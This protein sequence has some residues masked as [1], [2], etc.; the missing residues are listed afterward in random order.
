MGRMPL[1]DRRSGGSILVVCTVVIIA[2][3]SM[4]PVLAREPLRLAILSSEEVQ[5]SGISD[6]LTVQMQELENVELVER[7]LLRKV[8]D[9]LTLSMMLGAE[10]T[11]NRRNVGALL[12]A[13]MLV[14][15]SAE[16]ADGREPTLRI[17]IGDCSN[18]ARLRVGWVPFEKKNLDANCRQLKEITQQTLDH[19]ETGVK[20]IIGV[21]HFISRDLVHDYNHLQTGYARLLQSALS[22]LPGVAVIEVE[23]A[24]SIARENELAGDGKIDRV[25][26]LFVEGE[27]RTKKGGSQEQVTVHLKIRISDNAATAKEIERQDVALNQVAAFLTNDVAREILVLSK[28]SDIKLLDTEKQLEVLTRNADEF[29]RVGD[30][31]HSTELR[32][33]AVLLK[34]DCVEQRFKLIEE[35]WEA[36]KNPAGW[37]LSL[38]STSDNQWQLSFEHLEYMIFNR[39]VKMGQAVGLS[40]KAF[41][42]LPP[43]AK[44]YKRGFLLTAYPRILDLEPSKTEP[45]Q[46]QS[47]RQAWYSLL[48]RQVESARW[49]S[50][51]TQ[52]DLELY[53]QL[54]DTLPNDMGPAYTFIL[55]L[56]DHAKP[57]W[58]DD[59]RVRHSY[60]CSP[61]HDDYFSEEDFLDFTTALSRSIKPLSSLCGRYALLFHKYH[62][63]RARLEPVDSLLDQVKSLA[64]EVKDH[65]FSIYLS[66]PFCKKEECLYHEIRSLQAQIEQAISEQAED[67]HTTSEERTTVE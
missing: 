53:L 35:Y 18:G 54:H 65:K 45:G 32:E 36:R 1:W 25:V 8:A 52:E 44:P 43:L 56:Q 11:E 17:T 55:F 23:E 34:P 22:S 48:V 49:G 66:S 15:L 21:S 57:G 47:E 26:P 6:L 38:E 51:P 29:A 60:W 7:D 37:R 4:C 39:M 41:A 10:H 67:T 13:D 12:K 62:F 63:R 58:R 40:G 46:Q 31:R 24:R 5:N 50:C 16:K 61:G 20:Q 33:A 30:W 14:I 42:R 9:E 2:L 28:S 3:F 64:N 59:S 27:F 19:F